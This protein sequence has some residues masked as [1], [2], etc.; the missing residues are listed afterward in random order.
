M[1]AA[2]QLAPWHARH[3][4]MHLIGHATRCTAALLECSH[5]VADPE[6]SSRLHPAATHSTS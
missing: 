1:H 3:A 2:E 6:G 4:L 5:V